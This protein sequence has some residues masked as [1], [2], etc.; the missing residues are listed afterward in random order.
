MMRACWLAVIILG[1]GS[2]AAQTVPP[3]TGAPP[4]LVTPKNSNDSML[5]QVKRVYVD[6]FGDDNVS[7]ELQSMIVSSLVATKRF[8]VTEN[9][10]H[11]DAILKGNATEKTSHE[12]HA[13]GETTNVGAAA[14]SSQSSLSGYWVNGTGAVSG[15]SQGGFISRHMGTGDSSLNTETINNARVALRL[16]SQD[17]DV[18]WTTTQESKGAKYKGATADAADMCVKKLIRDLDKLNGSHPE[19]AS[20]GTATPPPTTSK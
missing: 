15:S 11:A 4:A 5:L 7:K 9:R 6:S 16:V 19:A 1:L 18:I 13:Y 2:A 17:G 8:T 12:V 14:G 20:P 10:E 3:T